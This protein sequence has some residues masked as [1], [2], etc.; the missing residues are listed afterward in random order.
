MDDRVV[1]DATLS[2]IT[3]LA[4]MPLTSL[5][6][7]LVLSPSSNLIGSAAYTPYLRFSLLVM[8]SG[9]KRYFNRLFTLTAHYEMLAMLE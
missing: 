7:L 5:L 3:E 6:I 9:C 4:T 2:S 8:L 1:F